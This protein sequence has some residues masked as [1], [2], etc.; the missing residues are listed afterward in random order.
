[1]TG[2]STN[3]NLL[4]P[5]GTMISF[6]RSFRPSAI[7]CASPPSQGMPKNVTRFGPMRTCIQPITFRSQSVR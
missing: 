3:R 6:A 5:V 2:A 4:A 7:G 1:M